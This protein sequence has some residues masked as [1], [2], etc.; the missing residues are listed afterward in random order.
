MPRKSR[1]VTGKHVS[2]SDTDGEVNTSTKISSQN[3]PQGGQKKRTTVLF[4]PVRKEIDGVPPM[5]KRN[6][7]MVGCDSSGHLGIFS[8]IFFWLTDELYG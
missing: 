5:E 1:H 8:R 6:C 4:P 7:P 3:T 2:E